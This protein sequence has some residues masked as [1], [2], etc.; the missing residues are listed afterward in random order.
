[1]F[2]Q[3]RKSTIDNL[4]GSGRRAQIAREKRLAAVDS[5][6]RD[7]IQQA[8]R[9]RDHGEYEAAARDYRR[10]LR[11]Y[12]LHGGYWMQLGHARKEIG[13]YGAA[14]LAMRNAVALGEREG[15]QHLAFVTRGG[16]AVYD[17]AW[18]AA[19]E[20]YWNGINLDVM[21]T[22]PTDQDARDAIELLCD[23][24]EVTDD[25]VLALLRRCTSRRDVLLALFGTT[26]FRNYHAELLRY[27]KD[28]GWGR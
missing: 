25:E 9:A 8:D 28:T 21:A 23:R 10:A 1:M 18:I 4:P 11:L 14:E 24:G 20:D 19:I 2:W 13:R 15:E 17:P 7:L 16:G 6:F 5:V 26:E 22:P 27:I 12:P 3:R